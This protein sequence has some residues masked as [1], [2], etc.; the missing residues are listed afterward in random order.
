MSKNSFY[1]TETEQ[2]CAPSASQLGQIEKICQKINQAH[3]YRYYLSK[4]NRVTKLYTTTT[5]NY[6]FT[7]SVIPRDTRPQ[8]A[9]TLKVYVFELSLKVFEMNKFI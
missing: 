3:D 9:P 2:W 6:G 8:A 7:D 5:I 4:W 1:S